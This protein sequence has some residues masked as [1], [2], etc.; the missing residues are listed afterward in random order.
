MAFN[1]PNSLS[2]EELKE[3]LL[4][5]LASSLTP[6]QSQ[7]NEG[8]GKLKVLEVMEDY[9]VLLTQI[10]LD[11]SFNCRVFWFIYRL[12]PVYSVFTVETSDF[13]ARKRRK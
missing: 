11:T 12:I 1:N 6:D 3:F 10:A 4:S 7:R 5:G 13:P 2:D 8:E 9:G